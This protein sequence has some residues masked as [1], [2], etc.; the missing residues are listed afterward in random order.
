VEEVD[1]TKGATLSGSVKM[2]PG[3]SP[4]PGVDL[5]LSGGP[6]VWLVDNIILKPVKL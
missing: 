2:L 5:G 6:P 1:E 3:Q 4:R